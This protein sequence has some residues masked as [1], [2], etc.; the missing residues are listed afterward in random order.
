MTLTPMS[1]VD[2]SYQLFVLL[3]RTDVV[4]YD[5]GTVFDGRS[6]DN[7]VIGKRE[8]VKSKGRWIYPSFKVVDAYF[9]KTLR[10]L[11][12]G[13]GVKSDGK[14]EVGVWVAAEEG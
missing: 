5:D 2:L 11:A 13:E 6:G 12:A 7:D 1:R 14:G 8:V 9:Q 10:V 3:D 4:D